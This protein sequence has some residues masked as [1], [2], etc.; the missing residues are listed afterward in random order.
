M[1][2]FEE[3][4]GLRLII[5][6][7]E[8]PI[9]PR[10]PDWCEKFGHMVC[11][12]DRYNLGDFERPDLEETREIIARDDVV[13]LP[14]YLYD[15]SG[16]TMYTNKAYGQM[17]DP[18]GWDS[19]QVGWI[20]VTK[21]E[22]RKEY[23]VKRISKKTMQKA[24]DLLQSEVAEYDQFLTG[25]IYCARVETPDGDILDSIG[26]LYGYEYA[27]DY[28]KDM[29]DAAILAERRK[30]FAQLRTWIRNR[31]PLDKRT[32]CPLLSIL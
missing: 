19:G 23:G 13:S 27:L 32:P 29:A 26:G 5:E 12:H 21:D 7:E 1:E 11:F 31:V 25:D 15:H 16:I 18:Q 24:V 17:F 20:Y 22:I 3:Y 28:A 10:D 6:E 9:S 4:K 8:M 2:N 14:L 30:H